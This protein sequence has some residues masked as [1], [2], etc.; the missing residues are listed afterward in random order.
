MSC[1][2]VVALFLFYICWGIDGWP[3]WIA[4][5]EIVIEV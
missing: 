4:E 3:Y 5:I 2:K 1:S